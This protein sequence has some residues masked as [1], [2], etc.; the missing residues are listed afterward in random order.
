MMD[1]GHD[2]SKLVHDPMHF[3]PAVCL[4]C[5]IQPSSEEQTAW[6]IEVSDKIAAIVDDVRSGKLP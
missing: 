4:E 2:E 3:A 1:C 5:M 6:A